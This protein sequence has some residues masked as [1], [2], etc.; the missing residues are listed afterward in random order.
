MTTNADKY[1][2]LVNTKESSNLTI[3]NG[4]I[5]SFHWQNILGILADNELTF[6]NHRPKICQ[7]KG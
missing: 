1:Q 6:E 2:L 3:K 5:Q 4:S 7:K